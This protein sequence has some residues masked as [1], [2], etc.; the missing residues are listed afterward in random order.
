MEEVERLCDRVILLKDGTSRARFDR[1][2]FRQRVLTT[3]VWGIRVV[4]FGDKWRLFH[5]AI[6][7]LVLR[8]RGPQ[9]PTGCRWVPTERSS[10]S[11]PFAGYEIP[12]DLRSTLPDEGGPNAA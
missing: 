10:K 2:C 3:A 5:G 11:S 8:L 4:T 9:V 1:L 6:W 12:Y 7:R